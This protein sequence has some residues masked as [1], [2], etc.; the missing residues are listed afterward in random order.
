MT[1]EEGARLGLGG[2]VYYPH[3]P[4]GEFQ[5]GL[6]CVR[7]LVQAALGQLRQGRHVDSIF[8]GC[9]DASSEKVAK[10]LR[11]IIYLA[12]PILS[13]VCLWGSCLLSGFSFSATI[14]QGYFPA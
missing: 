14:G 4:S 13:V 3:P 7:H 2:N 8:R 9:R 11:I 12:G 5:A 6:A 1:R 10:T